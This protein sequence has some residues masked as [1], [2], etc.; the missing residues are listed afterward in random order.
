MTTTPPLCGLRSTELLR[1][2]AIRTTLDKKSCNR[3]KPSVASGDYFYVAGGEKGLLAAIE[4]Q[5]VFVVI[6]ADPHH[7]LSYSKG[8]ITQGSKFCSSNTLADFPLLAVGYNLMAPEPYIL[9]KNSQ[10]VSW[11]EQGYLRLAVNKTSESDGVCGVAKVPTY[12]DNIRNI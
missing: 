3:T 6:H 4:K 12:I 5:P 1:K 9:L 7:F 10:G 2:K 8:V 11:G